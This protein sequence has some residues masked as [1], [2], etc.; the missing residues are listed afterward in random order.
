[1]LFLSHTHDD[2]PVVEP[3]ALRLREIFGQD[4]VFY[5]SWSI[6][7]G[8][9]IV[10]KMNEGL[11]APDYVFFFV[12]AK[13]LTSNMVKL[14]WQNSVYKA[15][16]GKTRI[17]PVR[18]DG[19]DLPAIMAQNVY[20]DMYTQG[21]EAA[22][23]QIVSLVQGNNAFIPQHQSFSNLTWKSQPI[24]GGGT[25]IVITASHLFDP[26]ASIALLT[27]D[28]ETDFKVSTKTGPFVGGWNAGV[29]INGIMT[30]AMAYSPM[31]GGGISPKNPLRI[32]L[33]SGTVRGILHKEGD[34][35]KA[36]P[37]KSE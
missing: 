12:S 5:D 17:V 21:I 16:K 11:T 23:Q 22:I 28:A 30:N 18:V 27:D 33:D 4:Q 20:I 19:S 3:V 13:S 1:M 10:D 7:P 36:L 37:F 8:D 32:F 26:V 31:V 25:E 35:Y 34:E 15:T 9:G 14:E 2:K 24:G 29:Q 6:Q